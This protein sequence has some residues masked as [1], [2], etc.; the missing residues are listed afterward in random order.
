MSKQAAQAHRLMG[1]GFDIAVAAHA[2]EHGGFA[3]LYYPM[4]VLLVLLRRPLK[5]GDMNARL[6]DLRIICHGFYDAMNVRAL[7]RLP[8]RPVRPMRWM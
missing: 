7:P 8:A 3:R 2:Q 4:A 1:A 5:F 6:V